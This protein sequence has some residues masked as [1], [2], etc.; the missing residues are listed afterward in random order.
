MSPRRAVPPPFALGQRVCFAT[1][2]TRHEK[3]DVARCATRVCWK[4][5]PIL[6]PG[7]GVIV[8]YRTRFDGYTE[9]AGDNTIFVPAGH[10]RVA[11]VAVSLYRDPVVVAL[12]DIEAVP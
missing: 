4:P 3:F 8:G 12:P 1:R 10:Q 9:W 2:L 6:A 11:L 7:E 5:A